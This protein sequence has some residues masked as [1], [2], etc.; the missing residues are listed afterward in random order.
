MFKKLSPEFQD[1]YY[2]T[3]DG[4]LYN[5]KKNIYV[6]PNHKKQ[7]SIK[8]KD[9]RFISIA[10]KVLY[11]KIYNKIWC[12]DNIPDLENEEWKE[13]ENT[14]GLYLVSNKG[15]VKSLV[16]YK[17]KI[18]KPNIDLKG[19][20]R[21]DIYYIKDKFNKNIVKERKSQFIHRLVAFSFLSKPKNLED[22]QVHHK[23]FNQKNNNS[24]NLIWLTIEEHQKI[25]NQR[26]EEKQ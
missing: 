13:I 1:Y 17:A 25:H 23:D 18:L 5:S 21:V 10:L 11:K 7:F 19:Y 8:T 16:Q 26:E 24:D 2:L 12:I 14:D 3:S 9:G 15:R 22:Y 20:E 4:K 6:E